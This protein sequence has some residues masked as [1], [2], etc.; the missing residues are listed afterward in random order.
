MRRLVTRRVKIPGDL[1]SEQN[2]WTGPV[3]HGA[4]TLVRKPA[5]PFSVTYIEWDEWTDEDVDPFAIPG[6]DLT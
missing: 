5:F 6:W 1:F 3:V 4:I 2:H